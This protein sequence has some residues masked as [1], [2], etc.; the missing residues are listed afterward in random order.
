VWS[1]GKDAEHVADG[2]AYHQ[3][4]VRRTLGEKAGARPGIER[5]LLTARLSQREV[6][7]LL[8]QRTECGVQ[9]LQD[10]TEAQLDLPPRPPRARPRTLAEFIERVLIGHYHVHRREI[11]SKLGR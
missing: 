4:I 7:E 8:R 10:L 6:V 9:L 2:A 11:E 1:V 3:W 5:E